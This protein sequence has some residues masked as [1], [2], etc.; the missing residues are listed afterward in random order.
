[1]GAARLNNTHISL[2]GSGGQTVEVA[3]WLCSGGS[4]LIVTVNVAGVC[5]HRQ[6]LTGLGLHSFDALVANA[7][8][9]ANVQ[10]LDHG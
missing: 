2:T 10:G 6:K 4:D 1:M 7:A 8:V 3:A 9:A 5:V